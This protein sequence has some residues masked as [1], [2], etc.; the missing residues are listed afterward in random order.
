M[1]VILSA[2]DVLAHM[3]VRAQSHF[4]MAVVSEALA[5]SVGVKRWACWVPVAAVRSQRRCRWD[6]LLTR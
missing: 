2:L 4:S 6:P 5:R 3:G 1:P